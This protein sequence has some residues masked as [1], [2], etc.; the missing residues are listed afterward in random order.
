MFSDFLIQIKLS[1]SCGAIP[2]TPPLQIFSVFSTWPPSKAKEAKSSD[3][4]SWGFQCK[5]S[6]CTED[7]DEPVRLLLSQ[8]QPRLN[9]DDDDDYRDVCDDD[10]EGEEHALRLFPLTNLGF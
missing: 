4:E 5:C 10:Y 1:I 2:F 3:Q 8:L 6:A 7:N 9:D